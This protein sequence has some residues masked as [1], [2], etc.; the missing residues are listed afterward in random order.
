MAKDSKEDTG[1]AS[2]AS[3]KEKVRYLV[4]APTFV[5]GSYVDPKA[6]KDPVYVHADAGLEGQALKLAPEPKAPAP[7]EDDG[8]GGSDTKSG[9]GSKGAGA[10][11]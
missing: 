11:G 8:A 3:P 5:N 9:A 4:V 7:K 2:E 1:R 10:S 6:H